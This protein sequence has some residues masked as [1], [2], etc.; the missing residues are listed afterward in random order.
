[1]AGLALNMEEDYYGILEISFESDKKGIKEGFK[2]ASMK[3]HPDKN[4]GFEE[5]FILATKAKDILLNE[6]LRKKYDSVLKTRREKE[7]KIKE[8]GKI[9]QKQKEDLIAK[10][11]KY[12][13]ERA[14]QE[15]EAKEL[16][17]DIEKIKQQQKQKRDE[18]QNW[19]AEWK[20]P[21]ETFHQKEKDPSSQSVVKIAWDRK[22]EDYS[23]E[24]ISFIFQMF[25][26]LDSIVMGTGKKGTSLISFREEESARA[27][28]SYGQIDQISVQW[29]DSKLHSTSSH[30]PNHGFG[31]LRKR[32][33]SIDEFRSFEEMVLSKIRRMNQK[34]T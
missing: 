29:A 21:K 24:R 26:D 8:K 13:K 33:I 28:V 32:N 30:T 19:D 4:P 16:Y 7:I 18:R 9:Q 27:A 34:E 10:E 22:V 17:N 23:K 20:Q 25:G 6:E 3:Y 12:E 14:R 31:L 1:M 2:K 15:K 11:K 5:K